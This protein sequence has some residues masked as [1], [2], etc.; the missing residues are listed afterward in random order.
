MK[1]L[2]QTYF[3]KTINWRTYRNLTSLCA[4]CGTT[5]NIEMHH[6]KAIR[7]GK[8]TGFTQVMKQINR[9]QIPL[10]RIHHIEVERGYYDSIDI[11]EL[12]DIERFLF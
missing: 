2:T 9:K 10:C 7:K 8:V 5:E 3:M 6:V 4:L 12:I 11:S 1:T